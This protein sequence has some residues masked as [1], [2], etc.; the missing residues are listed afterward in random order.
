MASFM[1]SRN[2]KPVPQKSAALEYRLREVKELSGTRWSSLTPLVSAHQEGINQPIAQAAGSD[3]GRAK[4]IQLMARPTLG[5]V[6]RPRRKPRDF[7]TLQ[8]TGR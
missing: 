6:Q 4:D 5:G 8:Q 2:A 7:L 1:P 3:P